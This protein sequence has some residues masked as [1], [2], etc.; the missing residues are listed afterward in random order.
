MIAKVAKDN[1]SRYHDAVVLM[2]RVSPNVTDDQ[3]KTALL[4]TEMDNLFRGLQ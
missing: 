1:N 4:A 2:Q 3:I